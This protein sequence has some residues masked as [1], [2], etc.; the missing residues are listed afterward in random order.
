[1]RSARIVS[2]AVAAALALTALLSTAA[3]AVNGRPC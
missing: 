3:L 2:S 1:M